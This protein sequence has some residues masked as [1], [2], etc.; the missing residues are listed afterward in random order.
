MRQTKHLNGFGLIGFARIADASA[1]CPCRSGK[2][3]SGTGV[4]GLTG[5][6]CVSFQPPMISPSLTLFSILVPRSLLDDHQPILSYPLSDSSPFFSINVFAPFLTGT[7]S[8]CKGLLL[9]NAL[10]Y[11]RSILKSLSFCVSF[12]HTQV[13]FSV[14]FKF[15]FLLT[16]SVF[17]AVKV[18]SEGL[19]SWISR[20]HYLGRL[21]PL[22]VWG[23]SDWLRLLPDLSVHHRKSPSLVSFIS[24][25]VYL[26]SISCR[27]MLLNHSNA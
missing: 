11:I 27:I 6:V 13:C 15:I 16:F 23:L 25:H 26:T 1:C 8:L 14:P 18:L 21:H 20:G 3:Q 12:C 17:M 5:Q 4:S 7:F 22:S 19:Y 2:Y 24:L 9:C 10:T